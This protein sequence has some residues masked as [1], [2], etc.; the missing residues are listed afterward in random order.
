MTAPACATVKQGLAAAQRAR[1][2]VHRQRA[3]E[4]APLRA[5]RRAWAAAWR[6]TRVPHT[7]G[8]W[9]ENVNS[10]AQIHVFWLPTTGRRPADPP[11][12]LRTTCARCARSARRAPRHTTRRD[13]RRRAHRG[14]PK[15]SRHGA[16][17]LS[18]AACQLACTPRERPPVPMTWWTWRTR[19]WT[20]RAEPRRRARRLQRGGGAVRRAPP[21][22]PSGRHAGCVCH[23][24]ARRAARLRFRGST[25]VLCQRAC[26]LAPPSHRNASK[27]TGCRAHRASRR[28]GGQRR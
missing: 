15:G 26:Q 20:H 16:T 8:R 19:P 10:H 23:L 5:A 11:R 2:L 27:P 7:L 13:A 12:R 24:R 9:R 14:A 1:L 18:A 28:R 22:R 25:R 21:Q 6:Q 3:R 4:G 17:K